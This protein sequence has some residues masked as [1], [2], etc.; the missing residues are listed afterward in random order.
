MKKKCTSFRRSTPHHLLPRGPPRIPPPPP[1][2]LP[3]PPLPL[4]LGASPALFTAIF[5]G[6]PLSAASTRSASRFSD[7]GSRIDRTVDPRTLSVAYGC[8]FLLLLKRRRHIRKTLDLI[9]AKE[10]SVQH[11]CDLETMMITR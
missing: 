7:S 6:F 2:P 11:V 5:F 8:G 4:P 9:Q 10:C 3:L 1:L